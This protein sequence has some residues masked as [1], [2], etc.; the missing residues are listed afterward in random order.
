MFHFRQWF[1]HFVEDETLEYHVLNSAGS[2]DYFDKYVSGCL[3]T[4]MI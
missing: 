3:P 2:A 1:F 4:V